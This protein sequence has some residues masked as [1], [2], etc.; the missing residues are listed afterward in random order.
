MYSKV[1]EWLE[2]APLF[3]IF[4]VRVLMGKFLEDPQKIAALREKIRVQQEISYFDRG[5]NTEV[6]ANIL[7][8]NRTSVFV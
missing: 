4:R 8:I 6:A 3:E 2:Q 1:Y 7:R 5:L